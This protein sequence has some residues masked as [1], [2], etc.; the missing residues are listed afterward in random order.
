MQIMP[1]E[2]L[3]YAYVLYPLQAGFCKLPTLH[4]KLVSNQRT[5]TTGLDSPSPLAP[6]EEVDAVVRGML[7]SQIF[8]FPENVL[9]N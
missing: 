7:P 8:V 6:Q 3:D 2:S 4:V 5:G 9:P 1:S